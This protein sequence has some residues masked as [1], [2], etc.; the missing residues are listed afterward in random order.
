MKSNSVISCAPLRVSF[1]G[2]GTDIPDFYEKFGEGRVVS[3]A[4]KKYVYVHVKN[5]DSL[6]HEKYRV[7][8]SQVELAR[9][10]S[11]IQNGIVRRCLEYL[12]IDEPLHIATTGDIP[13]NSGLGSSSS[14][15][16][17]LLLALYSLKGKQVSAGRLAE[18]AAF[19]EINLLNEPI[20]K[21]DQYSAS[22]GGMNS[23]SFKSNG[24]VGIEPILCDIGTFNRFFSHSLLIWTGE[25][26][27]ASQILQKQKSNADSNYP[28]LI[29]LTNLAKEFQATFNQ[30][31]IT[32]NLDYVSK[33]ISLGWKLKKQFSSEISTQETEKISAL[34]DSLGALGY[35]LLG[36][37]GGGFVYSVFG[38]ETTDFITS[39]F[40]YKCFVPEIDHQG[41]RVLSRM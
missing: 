34:L 8:Y 26:R 14:F 17:A 4:I 37:G 6:F 25:T 10:R 24:Q 38:S 28:K 36:A 33:L 12:D 5:H 16:V 41:A 18:E 40:P 13:S 9:D 3:A 30:M 31:N 21:Q 27:Q 19:V 1:V 2:G 23:Y 39:L 32:T 22:F 15:T 7:S 20:G 29:E 11:D 35:K